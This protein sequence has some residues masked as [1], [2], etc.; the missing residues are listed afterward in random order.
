MNFS[1]NRRR[2]LRTTGSAVTA[3]LL[4]PTAGAAPEP[5]PWKIGCYT[6]PWD[7]HDYRVALDGIAEAGYRHVGIMTSKGTRW[8]MITVE[9]TPEEAA[10]IGASVRERGL[11]TLSV[12]GS[13]IPA[14]KSIKDGIAGLRTLI[15]H[16]V[17][18]GS[19]NLL[20]G[21][22]K[23]EL[24]EPYYKIVAECCDYAAENGVGMSVKPHGGANATSKEC[25]KIIESVKHPAFRMWYD[26]GNIF[27]YSGGRIDPV[28]DAVHAK[29]LVAGMSVKDYLPPDNVLVT[30]G[31]GKV[32]FPEVMSKLRKGGFTGG[33]LVVEC[34]APGDVAHITAE[35][36]KTRLF[37]EKLVAAGN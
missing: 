25:R 19:P 28:D 6:R 8:I 11:K 15:D 24:A 16:T 10:A 2:F 4:A 32:R 5:S 29:G 36:K 34:L 26:P 31:T 14:A 1:Q 13:G 30:P 17:A 27:Y 18:C 7:K 23:Q 21:G 35:A 9:T 22:T 37:L 20:L 12:Y 3:S 33:P